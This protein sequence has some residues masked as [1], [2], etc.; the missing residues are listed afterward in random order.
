[1]DEKE[2]LE[3]TRLSIILDLVEN[4]ALYSATY[5]PP[6]SAIYRFVRDTIYH[7]TDNFIPLTPEEKKILPT[8]ILN[9]I[10]FADNYL[11]EVITRH[12]SLNAVREQAYRE[13]YLTS[14]ALLKTLRTSERSYYDILK[15][16]GYVITDRMYGWESH[17]IERE[18]YRKDEEIE[19]ML[20]EA[21]K[22][23]IKD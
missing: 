15:N 14:L 23:E 13:S 1:M 3:E 16:Y 6:L 18:M 19:K 10:K 21:F 12:G 5:T 4:L 7:Y 2:R 11:F 20:D 9:G 8:Y 17:I 22:K